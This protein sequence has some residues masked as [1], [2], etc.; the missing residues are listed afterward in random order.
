MR[1]LSTENKNVETIEIMTDQNSN[2]KIA[3]ENLNCGSNSDLVI[4]STNQ[5][6]ILDVNS[7]FDL[8]DQTDREIISCVDL[9]FALKSII[10]A[11]LVLV[12]KIVFESIVFDPRLILE[13]GTSKKNAIVEN[14]NLTTALSA[15]EDLTPIIVFQ[16]VAPNQRDWDQSTW[17]SSIQK[18]LPWRSSCDDFST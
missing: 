3:T 6:I 13:I 2:R 8:I 18:R 1:N 11:D 16:T 10:N 5:G 12:L 4:D 15:A 7:G 17:W 14:M 9:A